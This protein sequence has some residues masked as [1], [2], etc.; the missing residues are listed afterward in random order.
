MFVIE[1]TPFEANNNA[2]LTTIATV[3]NSDTGEIYW[4]EPVIVDVTA[5]MTPEQIK[6]IVKQK[7]SGFTARV[8]AIELAKTFEGVIPQI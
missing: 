7:T 5:D 8:E 6:D 2:Q 3:K 1:F 4:T